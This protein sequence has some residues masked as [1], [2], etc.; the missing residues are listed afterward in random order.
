M[1]VKDYKIRSHDIKV[2]I[3]F[4]NNVLNNILSFRSFPIF[5]SSYAKV[6]VPIQVL[7]PKGSACM[8]YK[9][10]VWMGSCYNIKDKR[11]T[12]DVVYI[13]ITTKLS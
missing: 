8:Y 2:S 12:S 3:R 7:L 1:T 11:K 4:P 13:E 9:H 5:I 6:K 10:Y